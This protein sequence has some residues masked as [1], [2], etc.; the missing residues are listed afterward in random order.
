MGWQLTPPKLTWRAFAIGLLYVG[1]PFLL[2][3]LLLDIIF[4]SFFSGVL[5]SCYGVM[6]LF[7]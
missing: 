5:D 7:N 6:C 3:M 1:V 2:F 4:Y